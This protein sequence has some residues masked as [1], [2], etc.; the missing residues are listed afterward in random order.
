[1][2]KKVRKMKIRVEHFPYFMKTKRTVGKR[3][4]NIILSKN[5]I[6]LKR[7]A[8]EGGAQE[9]LKPNTTTNNTSNNTTTTVN[10]NL[11]LLLL[12]LLLIILLLLLLI[13]LEV[14]S[15]NVSSFQFTG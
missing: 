13:L 9:S 11:I 5:V 3:T 15:R 6:A 4:K 14:C 8:L 7:R 10:I 1:M 2:T 12:L